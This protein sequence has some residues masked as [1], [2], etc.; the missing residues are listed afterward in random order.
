MQF[1]PRHI[2]IVY[3]AN[4]KIWIFETILDFWKIFGKI[5]I[6]E[7]KIDFW[8]NFGFLEKFWIFGKNLD[9]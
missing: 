4:P 2:L 7:K 6:F 1:K 9:F 5:W 3:S 8:K